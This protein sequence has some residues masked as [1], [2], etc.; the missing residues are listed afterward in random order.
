MNADLNSCFAT[1]LVLDICSINKE[2]SFIVG[3]SCMKVDLH[4]SCRSKF[5]YTWEDAGMSIKVVVNNVIMLL[6]PDLRAMA[7]NPYTALKVQ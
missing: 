6:S 5:R 4:R 3:I 7:S 2:P 1:V